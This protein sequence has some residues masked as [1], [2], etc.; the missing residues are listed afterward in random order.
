MWRKLCKTFSVSSVVALM[1]PAWPYC[2]LEGISIFQINIAYSPLVEFEVFLDD[3]TAATQVTGID[4]CD[5]QVIPVSS[6]NRN[7]S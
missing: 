1:F 3:I 2:A 5:C 6:G 4:R 7:D